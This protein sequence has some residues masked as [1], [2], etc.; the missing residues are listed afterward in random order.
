MK[1]WLAIIGITAGFALGAA[2]VTGYELLSSHPA[3][4]QIPDALS[5]TGLAVAPNGDYLVSFNNKGDA[6][7]GST[8][9]ILRSKDQGKT[10]NS[11]PDS[12]YPAQGLAGISISLCNLP[13][14]SVLKSEGITYH[15]STDRK[16]VWQPRIGIVRLYRS[17]NAEASEW[18]FL[19]ELSMEGALLAPMGKVV[20]LPNGDLIYPLWR[21]GKVK[22]LPGALYGSGFHRSTDGGRTWGNFELAFREEPEEG[23]KPW[24]F[25]ESAFLVRDDGTIVGFARHDSHKD[26]HGMF[27]VTS[28]DNGVTWSKPEKTDIWGKFPCIIKLPEGGFFLV[29]GKH[30][31]RPH[32]RTVHFYYS[33][34]G[35]EFKEL[36]SAYYSR[37]GGKP[38]NSGTGGAQCA[39]AGPGANEVF[40]VYYAFD[41]E[42]EGHHQTYID[43]NRIKLIR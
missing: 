24:N 20:E 18:E 3:T 34:D 7:A 1:K 9:Y 25:N 27:R 17:T 41:P 40:F 28:S 43:C 36:G 16:A 42:L 22:K 35:L 38:R 33:D 4:D 30:N 5:P 32:P 6:A 10:W 13:D 2:P 37:T 39:I 21:S 29:C 14:G 12:E 23:E 8:A 19:Q 26:F 11:T 31:A 15:V